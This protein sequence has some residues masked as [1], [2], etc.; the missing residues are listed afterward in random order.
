MRK[1]SAALL[2]VVFALG[3]AS[4]KVA[5]NPNATYPVPVSDEAPAFLFPVNLS[6]L[7]SGGD[8]LAMGLT[9]TGGVIA[10][11]GKQ[12]VSGQQLFD[13]VGNL[14]FELA[15]S[16]QAQVAANSWE[17][18]GPAEPI[19]SGLATIMS[20]VIDGLV[21]AKL[22]DKPIKF[23]YIIA[24]HSHG[25]TGMGG[26]TL[27]VTSWGGLYDAETKQ[28][29]SYISSKDTYANKPEAVMAQ[30]PSAYNGII[31]KLI[32]TK[33]GSAGK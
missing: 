16:I 33:E 28:I 19:A 11:F 23:K 8:P 32:G 13:L 18:T 7:G 25:E 4:A 15:E 12:V 31:S 5:V 21:A 2:G 27:N 17:M 22:L 3:C 1:L 29:V 9:V 26:N 20:K 24:V 6:H 10:K 14:S 30:L